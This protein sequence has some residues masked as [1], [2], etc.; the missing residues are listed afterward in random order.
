MG[1][2]QRR[3]LPTVRLAADVSPRVCLAGRRRR[4]RAAAARVHGRGPDAPGRSAT[5]PGLEP[6]PPVAWPVI[7]RWCG[8]TRVGERRGKKPARFPSGNRFPPTGTCPSD[9]SRAPRAPRRR[10]RRAR[11]SARIWRRSSRG[12]LSS[13]ARRGRPRERGSNSGRKPLAIFRAANAIDL[14]SSRPTEDRPT[15]D[16]RNPSTATTC[17]SVP[18]TP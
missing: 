6:R 16:A 12:R 11:A 17:R 2:Q 13:E 14:L 3:S 8:A 7:G 15:G 10:S 18:S 5:T 9:T 4:R 1:F